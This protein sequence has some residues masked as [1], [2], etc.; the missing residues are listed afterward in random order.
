MRSKQ[1]DD[2]CC[3]TDI[4]IGF[5]IY[6]ELQVSEGGAG[7]VTNVQENPLQLVRHLALPS[8]LALRT[9]LGP[10]PNAVTPS[11]HIP[12]IADFVLQ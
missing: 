2:F 6:G 8:E 4:L 9:T 3:P 11:D 10:W 1:E 7:G 12:L 5:N